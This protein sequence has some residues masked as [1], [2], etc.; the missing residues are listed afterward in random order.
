MTIAA[1]FADIALSISAATG[2]GFH[3]A[4]VKTSGTHTYDTGGSIAT[5]GTPTSRACSAQVDAATE[6][7]RGDSDYR[8]KDMRLLVLAATLTGDLDTDATV[9]LLDGPHQG[10]WMVRSV[11]RDPAGVYYECRGRRLGVEAGS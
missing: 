4:L 2:A 5:P 7:M 8:E 1:A 6:D 9:Q 3:D 11:D 10:E